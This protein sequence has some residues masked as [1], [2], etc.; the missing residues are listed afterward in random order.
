MKE[1]SRKDVHKILAK[2][3]VVKTSTAQKK[4]ELEVIFHLSNDRFFLVHYDRKNQKKRYF[5]SSKLGQVANL[6]Y[7]LLS[8]KS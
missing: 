3:D 2:F 5:V 7:I 6:T 4:G 8:I 1:I